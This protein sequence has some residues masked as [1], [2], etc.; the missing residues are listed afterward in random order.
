MNLS[1]TTSYPRLLRRVLA[2]LAAVFLLSWGLATMS[3]AGANASGVCSGLD[4]GKIDTTGNPKSVTLT[5]PE[6][7]LITGYCVKAGSTKNGGGPVYQ[8]V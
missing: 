4:S 5:A 3:P 7:Q 2:L 8:S 1:I 6:G